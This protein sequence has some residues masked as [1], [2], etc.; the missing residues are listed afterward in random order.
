[1]LRQK[2]FSKI[3]KNEMTKAIMYILIH[4]VFIKLLF[5]TEVKN[6]F[7]AIVNNIQRYVWSF[8]HQTRILNAATKYIDYKITKF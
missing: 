6:T 8:L 4:D 1:M 5:T 7:Y 3:L 2:Q